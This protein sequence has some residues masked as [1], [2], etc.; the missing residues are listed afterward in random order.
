MVHGCF[1]H[2]HGC[3]LFKWPSTRKEFWTTK[4]LRNK[5]KDAETETA[6]VSMGWRTMTVWECAL[7]GKEKKPIRESINCIAYWLDNGTASA[8]IAGGQ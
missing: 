1:W 2:G 8:E 6:L 4:V 7:K 5:E 3:H